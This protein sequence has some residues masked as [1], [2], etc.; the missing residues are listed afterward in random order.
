V[1]VDCD[2][3][4]AEYPTDAEI[5]HSINRK[6]YIDCEVLEDDRGEDDCSEKLPSVGARGAIRALETVKSYIIAQ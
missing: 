6:A 2:V 4:A 3:I 5:I 1:D